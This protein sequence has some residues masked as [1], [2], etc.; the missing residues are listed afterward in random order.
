MLFGTSG[1][2]G[3]YGKE[4][5]EEL[6]MKVA[7]VFAD[8]DVAIARDTRQTGTTLSE[9]AMSGALARGR[10]VIRLGIVPT[11]TLALATRKYSCNG[12]MLTASH[13]PPE[14]NGLKLFS[15]GREISRAREGEVESAYGGNLQ[16]AQWDKVGRSRDD[17]GIIFEHMALVSSLVDAS[18]IKKRRPKVVLDCNGA[19]GALTPNLL[20]DLGCDVTVLNGGLSGFGRP[21]EPNEKNLSEL[22]ATV[23]KVGAD[24]GL[25]HDGDADR[26]IAVDELGR[27][28]PLDIQLAIMCQHELAK[29]KNK[30]IVSTMEASLAVREAVES[31]GGT[32]TITPVGSLY[33]TE[34]LERQKALFGGE[35]CGEY[36]YS[37]GVHV[38]DGPLAA[39]KL[40]EIFAQ[41]GPLSALAG[42]FKANPM[43][44][45]KFPSKKKY[46]VVDAVK[47]E[48]RIKG[49]LSD[50]DGI[51]ID[52]EDGW[53]LIRASGTEPYVRLTME[54][55]SKEKLVKRKEELSSLI[56]GKISR[57][58]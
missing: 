56:R 57:L 53:F 8:R 39:A 28:L 22:S 45:E 14:Y 36:V 11:P 38:P 42:K 58:G 10:D 55:E 46:E 26:T 50:E 40:V 30:K 23:P 48:I 27:V 3:I 13:N 43:A 44:R 37:G 6:A 35:P 12:I 7:N 49:K 4:V 54:Y 15:E 9:A 31:E 20:K 29:S 51:R 33:V 25:A 24:I 5:T 21:S 17:K 19:G 47:K 41:E 2:R 34:E 1:I 32:V 18:A 52:E 16:I